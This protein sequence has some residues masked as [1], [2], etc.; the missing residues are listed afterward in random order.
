MVTDEGLHVSVD[1]EK[2]QV[3]SP[4]PG[5]PTRM[6]FGGKESFVTEDGEGVERL[7]ETLALTPGLANRVERHMPAVVAAAALVISMRGPGLL[8]RSRARSAPGPDRARG[9]QRA[10]VGSA[11]V[12]TGCLSGSF[13]HRA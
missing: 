10:S 13:E 12:A 11:Y 6:E 7:R 5:T 2:L 9:G 1:R 3:S 4:L 8:G